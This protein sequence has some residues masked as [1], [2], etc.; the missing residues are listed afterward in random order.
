[1]AIIE[2]S[3]LPKYNGW[4]VKS[5]HVKG[6]VSMDDIPRNG[7]LIEWFSV[8]TNIS[9]MLWFGTTGSWGTR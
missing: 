8:S 5:T 7:G 1:M 4:V 6:G 9:I 3:A 2:L